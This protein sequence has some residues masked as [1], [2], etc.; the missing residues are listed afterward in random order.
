MPVSVATLL[1]TGSLGLT[2]HTPRAPVDRAISWVHVSELAD[3]TPFLEGGE[4]LLT[5]GLALAPEGTAAYV[6]RLA[7]AGV[8]GLGLGTGLSHAEVPAGLVA[9]ADEHGLA[10]LEVPRQTPFIALSRTV[11]SALAAEEYAAVTRT[12]TVQR[13]LTRAAVAPG[14]PGTIVDRLARHLG[15]WALLL[16]AAGTAVEAAPRSA[17]GRAGALRPAADRLRTARPP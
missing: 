8:V 6:R 4:L 5:T 2:L 10:V 7:E 17:R 13:E 12:S 11:S 15:G 14:A 3:P 9:S 16:D 1:G